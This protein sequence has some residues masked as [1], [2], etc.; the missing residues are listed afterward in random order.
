MKHEMVHNVFSL[1]PASVR[2]ILSTADN[3]RFRLY[4][5][6]MVQAYLQSLAPLSREVYLQ[7]KQED[8]NLQDLQHDEI[9]FLWK[10]FYC[11]CGAGDNW[12]GT[13]C[14]H[15]RSNLSMTPCETDPSLWTRIE[16]GRLIGIVG[17]Y[18][19][20]NLN[21]GTMVFEYV[22]EKTFKMFQTKPREYGN[23]LFFGI[24]IRTINKNTFTL[25]QPY[26][27]RGLYELSINADI[28][29]Y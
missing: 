19:K 26:Y 17:N 21:A 2:V 27:C 12:E 9:L 6:D 23:M 3:L 8:H 22:M 20:D 5:H 10:P 7:L 1:R 16:N 11:M 15:L 24:C 14:E 28:N 25:A 29:A 18:V 13:I 4:C